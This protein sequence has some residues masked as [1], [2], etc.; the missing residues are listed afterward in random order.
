MFK[1]IQND[2]FLADFSASA[3]SPLP[4]LDFTQLTTW[5]FGGALPARLRLKTPE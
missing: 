1:Q 2:A 4:H 3:S 5:A